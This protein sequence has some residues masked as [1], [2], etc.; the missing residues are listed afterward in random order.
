LP[1]GVIDPAVPSDLDAREAKAQADG[2]FGFA[3][4]LLGMLVALWQDFIRSGMLST[5]A[6]ADSAGA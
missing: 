2:S 5:A 6:R 1:S 4:I 3:G